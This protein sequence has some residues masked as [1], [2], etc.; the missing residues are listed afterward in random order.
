MTGQACRCGGRI[1]SFFRSKPDKTGHFGWTLRVPGRSPVQGRPFDRLRTGIF[2]IAASILS[3]LVISLAVMAGGGASPP[4][5]LPSV[6][7][8][9]EGS[10]RLAR[11]ECQQNQ[12][13]PLRQAQGRL[14][15]AIAVIFRGLTCRCP[16]YDKSV[17][18]QL[19]SV[20]RSPLPGVGGT[21]SA[22][23]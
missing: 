16:P 7:D 11:G 2:R 4:Q 22:S 13:R 9:R 20:S 19:R 3:I 14:E 18:W 12:V 15:D 1:F 10:P 8:A 23:A 5:Y 21:R 17:S 6:I